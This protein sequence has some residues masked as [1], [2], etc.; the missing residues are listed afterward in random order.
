MWPLLK[1]SQAVEI[2]AGGK[3]GSACLLRAPL[4]RAPS[5]AVSL[6]PGRNPSSLGKQ[7]NMDLYDWK[8][9]ARVWQ[10]HAG[11]FAA[12]FWRWRGGGVGGVRGGVV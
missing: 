10:P 7:E 6:R 9:A 5:G 8:S 4:G 3:T 11:T 12:F 1:P 2:F